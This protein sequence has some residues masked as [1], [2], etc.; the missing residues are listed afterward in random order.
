MS[1]KTIARW[2][3]VEIAREMFGQISWNN[4]MRNPKT[5]LLGIP[6][7]MSVEPFADPL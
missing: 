6:D 3:I 4:F 7:G 2:N 5:N 1:A